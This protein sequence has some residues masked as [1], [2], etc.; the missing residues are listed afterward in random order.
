M[1]GRGTEVFLN[2]YRNLRLK[3]KI[4]GAI[5][6]VFGVF[7]LVVVFAAQ[8]SR[9]I[10][11]QA[12]TLKAETYPAL[13]DVQSLITTFRYLG[14]EFS[15]AGT[16]SD[17]SKL[18]G[19]QETATRFRKTFDHLKSISQPGDKDL[20]EILSLFVKYYN[21]G[22]VITKAMIDGT[23]FMAMGESVRYY[24]QLT[25]ELKGRLDTYLR[26]K[27]NGFQNSME[28]ITATSKRITWIV[29]GVTFVVIFA[30]FLA[31]Y[32]IAG[33]ITRPIEK[34]TDALKDIA[35][36][37]GDLTRRLE[38]SGRDE[39]GELARWFNVLMDKL[40]GVIQRVADTTQRVGSSAIQLSAT[41]EQLSKGTRNQSGQIAQ[42]ATAVE[43]MSATVVEV[44]RNAGQ[45]AQSAKKASDMASR[46]GEIVSQTVQSMKKIAG[47]VDE[48][49]LTIEELGRN[50]DQI[51]AIVGVI[52]EIADQTNLLALNA[53]IEA[54]RAGEHG[55]G[56]AVVA[57]EVRKL[58]D[59]TTRATKEIKAKIE[60]IQERTA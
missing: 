21:M 1:K 39:I 36:G 33:A 4:G 50:S 26:N 34:L 38:V 9:E 43:E 60:M 54:A 49:A 22:S 53:A 10:Q 28:Q 25:S 46:G 3:Y 32:F 35:Q 19:A 30:G 37:E 51:G 31:T 14:Q 27:E 23:D 11:T 16:F 24:S 52:N 2:F 29:G 18:E 6:L 58:A 41:S 47:S 45:A 5:S 55:R 57:D 20:E 40:H 59:R 12:D 17:V 7:L 15:S 56:F 13:K 8:G 48:S 42:V 44:A